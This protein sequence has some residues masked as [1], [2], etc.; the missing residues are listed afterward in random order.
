MASVTDS[1]VFRHIFST[2]ESSDIWSDQ[3]RT[4]YYLQFEAALARVQGRLGV[5]PQ[6]AADAIQSKCVFEVMD[7]DELAAVTKQIGYPVL[8]VVKQLVRAVNGVKEGLGEWVH[9]GATTQV[10]RKCLAQ[11]V[12]YL[13]ERTDLHS[14]TSRIQRRCSS[15]V[16]HA[17][18][19]LWP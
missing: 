1:I 15:C 17:T 18:S 3:T 2:P 10:N 5:I 7:M 11:L 8:P 4:Q 14:R 9:W 6:D 16:I 19:F 12:K 13:C